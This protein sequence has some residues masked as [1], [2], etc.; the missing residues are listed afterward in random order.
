MQKKILFPVLLLISAFSC[1]LYAQ[2]NEEQFK[3]PFFKLLKNRMYFIS[4]MNF[5]KQSITLNDYNSRFNYDLND[6][7]KNLYKPAYFLGLRWESKEVNSHKF[8]V[9]AMLSKIATGNNYSYGTKLSPFITNFSKFLAEDQFVMLNVSAY[10]KQLIPISD[11]SKY[12]LYFII[13]PTI[14]SR[15]S[16][17]SADNLINNNYK[18]YYISGDGGLEFNNQSFYTLFVHYKYALNSFTK[19]PLTTNLN[20]IELGAMIKLS[21]IF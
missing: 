5:N 18:Q 1:Q 2:K 15:L 21:D 4:G 11:T 17:Q 9:T 14:N 7:Q 10:Y 12:R 13:G 6:Y 3:A 8:A 19:S 20:S 16:D